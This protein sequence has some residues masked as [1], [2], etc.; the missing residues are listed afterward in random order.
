MK[1][2]MYSPKNN[3]N[4]SSSPGPWAL[5]PGLWTIAQPVLSNT[6]NLQQDYILIIRGTPIMPPADYRHRTIDRLSAS[7]NLPIIG[8]PLIVVYFRGF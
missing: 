6:F 8:A 5:T 7:N 3:S 4:P 2:W 1:L